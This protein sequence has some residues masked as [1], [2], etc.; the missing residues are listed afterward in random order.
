MSETLGIDNRQV[1]QQADALEGKLREIASAGGA[2]S[3]WRPIRTYRRTQGL[4]AQLNSSRTEFEKTLS[5]LVAVM[6]APIAGLGFAVAPIATAVVGAAMMHYLRLQQAWSD[7]SAIIQRQGAYG[8]GILSLYI[9]TVALGVTILF[10]VL[11][12]IHVAA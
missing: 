8:L 2:C 9:A 5:D 1:S 4:T 6:N 11:S 10:G 3:I 7:A 12:L